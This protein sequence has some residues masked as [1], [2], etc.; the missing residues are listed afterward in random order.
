MSE[1]I[2]TINGWAWGPVMLALLLG[3]GF[4]LSLGLR[5]LTV[6][7]IPA[8]MGL[9]LKG[10]KGDGAGDISPFSAL[11][12]SLSATIGTG[13]IAGVATAVALG[14]P[15]A[16]FWMWITA[17][18]GMATKYA[19]AVC[20]VKFREQDEKGNYS[21]GPM[22][23]IRNGLHPRWHWLAYAFALFGSLAG[24]GIA[25]TVQSNS[26]SQALNDAFTVPPLATG[27]VLMVL[28]GAV[29][30]GGIKR[31]ASV[32]SYLVPIMAVSYILLSIVVILMNITAVPAALETIV[33][34]A[35]SGSAAAGG[36][37][38]ASV[39]AALRFGVARGIFSNEAGLG[40]API[41]HA[42]AK[43]NQPVQQGMIAMLGTFIDTLVVCTMTGLVIVIMDV[44]PT[45]VSG[46]SLTSMAFGNALPGGEYIVTLGLCLFAFTTMIGWSFYGERCVVFLVGAKGVLPFRILWVLAI[47]VGTVVQ[48]D[49]VWLIADTL[50]AFMAVPNLIALLLLGPLVFKLT[51]EY[52]S[53]S[54]NER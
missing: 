36:F 20:A 33:T 5:F 24:F 21:G 50:N 46:A 13:N 45:G 42:A 44:L 2:T 12:T 25:N 6:R 49:M 38:G 34:S 37:A 9:L 17:L 31:I 39:W 19:E 53:S 16:L 47:P 10:R 3:T 1:I 22:Y 4:Y 28:V 52:F 51:R 35:M 11:M 41:A 30:L 27:L 18:V 8:A 54:D 48:L 26:V 7:K 14:G 43:T 23:Y 32:A 15:G 29:V 40:S